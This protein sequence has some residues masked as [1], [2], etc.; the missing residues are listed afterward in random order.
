MDQSK[1]A[2]PRMRH[3]LLTKSLQKLDRPRIKIQGCWAHQVCLF[4]HVVE[5]RQ[6]S[7]GSTVVEAMLKTIEYA[8]GIL[9]DKMPKK[10]MI[11]APSLKVE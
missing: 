2:V 11:W 3:H 5:V 1:W 8:E 6:P 10:I 9:K 4:L 7:D